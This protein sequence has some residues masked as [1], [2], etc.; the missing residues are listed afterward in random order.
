MAVIKRMDNKGFTLVELMISMAIS[1]IVI[2]SIAYFMNYS[3]KN[4]KSAN[5]EVILQTEAQAILNQLNDL[6]I[7]ASNVK[8]DDLLINYL[9]IRRMQMKNILFLLIL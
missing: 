1:V 4:Y 9:F 7:E 3:S 6:I 8:F 2:A 5:D